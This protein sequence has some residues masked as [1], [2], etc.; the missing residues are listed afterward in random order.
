MIR[1]VTRI[2]DIIIGLIEAILILQLVLEFLDANGYAGFTQWVYNTAAP[3]MQPFVGI[4]PDVGVG[5]GHVLDLST[6]CAI[7]AYAILGWLLVRLLLLVPVRD[8]VVT[9]RGV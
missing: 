9:N 8:V 5:G 2:V 3:F 1:L 4:F 6:L 7:V